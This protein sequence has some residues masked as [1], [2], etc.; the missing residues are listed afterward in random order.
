MANCLQHNTAQ[1][2]FTVEPNDYWPVLRRHFVS[3]VCDR[4]VRFVAPTPSVAER[5]HTIPHGLS[6]AL[7]A[8]CIE[9][10]SRERRDSRAGGERLR[11]VVLGSL[12]VHKGGQLLRAA[13]PAL[14]AMADLVL[15][16]PGASGAA[17]EGQ[18][19][20]HI[21][22]G[23]RREQLGV[24]LAEQEA[25]LGLLLSTVP[26]TFSYTLSELQ[27][28]GIPVVA[29]ALGAFADRIVPRETGWLV[30]PTAEAL[31]AQVRQLAAE[32]QQITQVRARLL[33]QTPR[34]ARDMVRDYTALHGGR[35]GLAVAA[36]PRDWRR[37]EQASALDVLDHVPAAVAELPDA[38]LQ[39]RSRL[40]GLLQA[41]LRLVRRLLG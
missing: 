25:D 19:G 7:V 33:A 1:R 5:F 2:F 10:R 20:V 9:A 36:R 18:P 13:L 3:G 15:L 40:P 27:A 24:L 28:A 23:Y 35:L 11:L 6:S 26:E 38:T 37:V 22:S 4:P 12:E 21:V 41:P 8:Q 16:G 14:G 32:R 34:S 31:I 30:Q 29:T 39:A 17:F